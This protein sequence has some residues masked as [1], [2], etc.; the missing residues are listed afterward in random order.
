[1]LALAQ[2][3]RRKIHDN[4]KDNVSLTSPPATT[5]RQSSAS[6]MEELVCCFCREID[7]ETNL[8]A[9]GE[10]HAKRTKNNVKHV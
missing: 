3:K 6:V 5:R 9:A 7:V 1:M 2:K 10:Y 4:D 8:C